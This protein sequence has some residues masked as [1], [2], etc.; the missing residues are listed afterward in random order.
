LKERPKRGVKFSGQGY[1]SVDRSNFADLE[2][3]FVV[4]VPIS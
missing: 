1:V 3:E 2:E 4:K